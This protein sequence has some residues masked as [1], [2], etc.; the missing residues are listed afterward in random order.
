LKDFAIVGDI[1]ERVD[2]KQVN[3]I[4]GALSD[5]VVD[6]VWMQHTKCGAWMDGPMNNFAIKN[7]RIVDMT[8]DG[9]NFHKGVTNSVVK[10]TFLRNTGDDGLAMW[11]QDVPNVN[12]KF[13]ENTIGIPVLANNIANRYPGVNGG[14][15]CQNEF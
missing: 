7:S 12:N 11:A 1:R 15:I 3:A 9:V 13:I 14:N 10:N 5:S 8:A 4:G 2:E 6:N